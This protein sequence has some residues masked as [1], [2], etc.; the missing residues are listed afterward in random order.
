M[1]AEDCLLYRKIDENWHVLGYG[2]TFLQADFD[3]LQFKEASEIVAFDELFKVLENLNNRYVTEFGI[4]YA[5]AYISEVPPE[6][7]QE[8]RVLC[9]IPDTERNE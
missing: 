3:D 5:G 8:H 2:F 6:V 1:S 4:C 7:P 9:C